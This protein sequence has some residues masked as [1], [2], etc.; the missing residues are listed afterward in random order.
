[1]NDRTNVCAAPYNAIPS[2]GLSDTAAIQ[3]A[4]NAGSSIYFPPGTYIY[5]GA[6]TL[7]ANKSYR[8]YGDGPGVSTILFTGPGAGINGPTMGTNTLN[9]EGLTLMASSMN[10]GTAI[11]ASFGEFG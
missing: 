10:C 11:S 1:M 5:Q 4:V 6:L 7:P 9:V 3:A 8:L 2:D